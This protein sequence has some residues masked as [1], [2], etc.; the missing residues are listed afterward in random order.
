MTEPQ[1]AHVRTILD[2]HNEALAAFHD[3]SDA[4]GRAL[5]S[6]RGLLDAVNEANEAQGRAINRMIAANH[7]ALALYNDDDGET[8]R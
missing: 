2:A 6:M 1:R 8:G 7:A 5:L 3:A 4:F